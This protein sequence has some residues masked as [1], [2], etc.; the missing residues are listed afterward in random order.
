[1]NAKPRIKT[2]VNWLLAFSKNK[3]MAIEVDYI[4]FPQNMILSQWDIL[5][6]IDETYLKIQTSLKCKNFFKKYVIFVTSNNEVAIIK[7]LIFIYI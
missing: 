6:L 4:D 3:F 1:M 2:F 7:K 5:G